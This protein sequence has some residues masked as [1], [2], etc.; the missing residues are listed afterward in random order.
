MPEPIAAA[1]IPK[2]PARRL[3][4]NERQVV[5]SVLRRATAILGD[6]DRGDW[7]DRRLQRYAKYRGWLPEKTFPWEHCSNVHIPLLQIAEL[8]ANAGLHNVIMTLRPLLTAVA[9]NRANVVKEERISELVDAQLFL[10]PGPDRAER[11]FSDYVSNF[12]QDGNA[13]AF[14]PW[15]RDERQVTTIKYRPRV[16]DDQDPATYIAALVAGQPTAN[17]PVPGL[18]PNVTTLVPTARPYAY[19]I[20]YT[21]GGRERLATCQVYQAADESLELEFRHDATLFD[22]PVIQNIP[23][24]RLLVPTRCANLQ[25]PSQQNADGAPYVFL[26]VRYQVSELRRLQAS[27]EFNRLTTEDLEK[28]IALAKTHAGLMPIKPE[29]SLQAQRDSLEGRE[30]RQLEPQVDAEDALLWVDCYMAFDRWTLAGTTE[31]VYF[32]V[33]RDAE[34]L[35]EARRLTEKW[36]VDLDEAPYR[37]LAEACAIPVP[38]R[39]YGISLLELGEALYDLVKGTFDQAYDNA[40]V[41]NM[42]WF[43]Y[44]AQQGWRGETLKLEPGRGNPVPGNP[45]DTVYVPT[46]PGQNQQFAFSIIGLALGFFEQ[47]EGIG[48]LQQGRV[49]RGNASAL[50]T[51]G[52]TAAILQQGDVRADQLLIRIFSGLRQIARNFHRMN[53]YLLPEG[54][55]FRRL[56]YDGPNEQAYAT[57]TSIAEIDAAADFDFR[58]DFL[59]SNQA[60]L[61]TTLQEVMQV[62]VTPMA[63][64]LGITDP[65]LVYGLLRDFIRARR[66]DPKKYTKRPQEDGRPHVLA[67]EF[68]SALVDNQFLDA[69]PLEGAQNHL[70]KLFA[71][72]KSEAFGL[73]QRSPAQLEMFRVHLEQIARAAKQEQLA[74]SA[75]QFQTALTQQGAGTRGPETT[76][77]EPAMATAGANNGGGTPAPAGA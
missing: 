24:D 53:R 7:M 10:E 71:F 66:L 69:A 17:P 33:A 21:A 44:G 28:I 57:I 47:V 12:C 56:G 3:A 20:T 6:M 48:Q 36:P 5:E 43:F 38:G 32:L 63:F 13:V 46:F 65:Q 19:E 30:H 64:Q 9:T 37:P 22:G 34:V 29:E 77:Q 25:P 18:L 27:G 51:F 75:G 40:T 70:A 68:I 73:L 60:M 74:A 39:Y 4:I 23:I 58:P 59:L 35:L 15:V 76:V 26:L 62:I 67:E 52:T 1:P 41:A 42:P 14:T 2:S 11:I 61:A 49:A 72:Q 55:E 16:P 8:R 54:K 45:R 50:R 31:D